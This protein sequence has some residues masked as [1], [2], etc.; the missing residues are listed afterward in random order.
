[1]KKIFCAVLCCLLLATSCLAADYA[2][3]RITADAVVEEDGKYRVS[4]QVEIHV[5]T[6]VKEILIPVARQARQTDLSGVRGSIVK[7]DGATYARLRPGDEF[8]GE[9]KAVI[10]YETKG[11]VTASAQGQNFLCLLVSDL[12]EVPVE[13]FS[14]SVVLPGEPAAQPSFFSSYTADD[15]E[16]FLTSAVS[17]RA[18]SG[19]LR[20]GLKDH[21]SFTMALAVP[22]GFFVGVSA[23][24]ADTASSV[25]AWICGVLGTLV[26]AAAGYYWY[27]FLRSGRLRVQARTLPPES[28]TPAEVP[29]LLCGATPDFGLLVCHWGSL[30]YLTVTANA[31]GRVILRKSMAMG[32]ERREEERKLFAM[33]FDSS[34]VCEAGG[35]RYRKTAELAEKA[36]RGFWARRLFDRDS[37]SPLL[38]RAAA[39]LVSALALVSTMSI[40]LPAGGF[41][42]LLLIAAFVAGGACGTA[43]YYGCVRL[44]VKDWLWVGIGAG[45]FLILYLMA[46][47]GGGMY[48]MLLALALCLATGFITRS[49]GRRTASGSDMVEQTRGF[50]RF[51]THAEDLH[52]TQRLQKDGQFF[53]AMLLY[54]AACGEGRAFARRFEG[55]QL[56]PCAFIQFSAP[57]PEQAFAWYQRFEQLRKTMKE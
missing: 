54:A 32:S 3:K 42:W 14:F 19:Q 56:E 31:A 21:E 5:E 24:K 36:L 13:R 28:L 30:G 16:D 20:G 9:T 4:Q 8:T 48:L 46:R 40:L 47:V 6:P 53:Y 2:V 7:K 17:G 45:A 51:L 15:V 55:L 34:D 25:M 1:M 38:L 11:E 33:L 57:V 29:Y 12:W 26:A 27:R 37:G 43:V 22:E 18:V 44:A 35:S 41:K 50:C 49:G 39:T 10:T 23:E 52:M